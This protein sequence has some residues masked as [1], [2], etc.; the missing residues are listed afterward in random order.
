MRFDMTAP[1]HFGLEAVLKRELKDLGFEVTRVED[2]RVSFTGDAAD[3]CRANICLR[4][5]GRILLDIG[6]FEAKTFDEL[7][8]QTRALP[9]ERYIPA[10]GRFGRHDES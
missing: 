8:E 5:A 10:D 1:C 6:E 3:V 2:G 4:T 9:W 7:F